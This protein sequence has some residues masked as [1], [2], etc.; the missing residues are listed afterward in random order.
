MT[1]KTGQWILC[2]AGV[3]LLGLTLIPARPTAVAL[4]GVIFG[5]GLLVVSAFMTRLT[6]TL[7]MSPQ[8][9]LKAELA[10]LVDRRVEQRV[11]E[12]FPRHLRIYFGAEGQEPEGLDEHQDALFIPAEPPLRCYIVPISEESTEAPTP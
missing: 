5:S 6:G 11:E 8:H 9:G 3:A 12:M 7:V 2:G 1:A 10:D 4:A